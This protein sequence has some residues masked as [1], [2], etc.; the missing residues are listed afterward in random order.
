MMHQFFGPV[1]IDALIMCTGIYW[2]IDSLALHLLMHRFFGP[3]F[4]D[5]SILR[6]CIY[7]CIDSSA[8]HVLMHRFFGPAF[9]DALILWLWIHWCIDS[10]A[11]H[12]FIYASILWPCLDSAMHWFDD[13]RNLVLIHFIFELQTYIPYKLRNW[14]RSL[15]QG[16][17]VLI[18]RQH[19]NH[20]N[21][22]HPIG[23]T[24]DCLQGPGSSGT[25]F[26]KLVMLATPW[27]TR[28]RTRPD[29]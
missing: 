9:S 5:A 10:S 6:P 29:D 15:P 2:C 4:I 24:S 26:W 14:C 18:H 28:P 27:C 21:V 3:A 7:W 8:L 20:D 12:W 1:F 13:A 16:I 25:R 22:P 19:N 23:G 17:P 11:V